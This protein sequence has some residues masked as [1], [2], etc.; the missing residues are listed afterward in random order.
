MIFFHFSSLGVYIQLEYLGQVLCFGEITDFVAGSYVFSCGNHE[1][2]VNVD[3]VNLRACSTINIVTIYLIE[4]NHSRLAK[5]TFLW[6][7]N[8]RKDTELSST[9]ARD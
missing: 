4:G 8:E 7:V 6:E 5:G 9:K 3:Q 2:F 1:S